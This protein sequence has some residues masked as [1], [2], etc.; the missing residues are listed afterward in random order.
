[1]SVIATAIP[2]A[3][4]AATGVIKAPI[5]MKDKLLIAGGAV[6]GG[7]VSTG[8]V[9]L[10]VRHNHKKRDKM[11]KEILAELGI[12]DPVHAAATLIQPDSVLT[13]TDLKE[14]ERLIADANAEIIEA[15]ATNNEE[16]IKATLDRV[17]GQESN[18]PKT[19]P[20]PPAV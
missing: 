16:I 2:V 10:I 9:T 12:T 4:A 11:R 14:I 13:E 18:E 1:M 15:V 7:L 17:L 20:P 8:L 19:P 3:T 6:G 5:S